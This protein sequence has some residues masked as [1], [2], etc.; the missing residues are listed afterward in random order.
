MTEQKENFAEQIRKVKKELR[1]QIG[2]Y[3]KLFTEIEAYTRK[4][5]DRIKQE[6]ASDSA[7]PSI[8]FGGL[9]QADSADIKRVKRAGCV[10]IRNTLPREEVIEQNE[11]LGQYITDNG[12]YEVK[13]D[14]KKDQYF[15]ELQ[16]G[17]PQIFGIYWSPTQIW[18]RQH[19]HLA[20]A[21]SFLNRLWIAESEG[22][23][24]FDPDRECTYADRVRRREP[25][26]ASL[27]LS[28]H[29]DAG[30][31]ERWLDENYRKVYRHIFNNDFSQYD[32]FDGAYRTQVKEIPSP[33]VA[34]VFRTFQ[35][36]TALTEQGPGDGT[37]ML[38]PT[39]ATMPYMLLRALQDDVAEDDLCGAMPRRAMVINRQW[40]R[41]LLDG[42]V[43]IPK[44]Y[45]GDTVWWHP[46]T[47]HAV[48]EEHSGEGYSNVIY[49]GAAP[50]CEKNAAFLP[51]QAEAFLAGKSSPDFADEDY[52]ITYPNCAKLEDLTDLG[53]IQMGF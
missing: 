44:V 21:R 13:I 53:K 32:P 43:T 1:A 50:Y 4:E 16:S 49:I 7:V 36:W 37:L 2:D 29:V 6:S 48:E 14:P 11:K 47:I 3:T 46:D 5:I 33:A 17:R 20:R 10:I 8:E 34:S 41:V 28:P 31:V 23:R 19:P 9:D 15:G 18:A 30:S 26:S 38:V 45:P 12:Y 42:L 24:H 52:E 27:G 35:G 51:R 22:S 40:H 25:K 39:T